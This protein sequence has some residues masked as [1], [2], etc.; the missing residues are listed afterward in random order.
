MRK[1]ISALAFS[2]L[3]A[4]P[5]WAMADGMASLEAFMKN[6][7]A[8]KAQFTQTVT[9]PGRDGQPGRSKT[10]SGEFQFQRPGKFSFN[11][12]KPFEQLIVADGKTLWMLDKDL[13]QVTQRAQAQALGS[14]PAAIL[15]SATDLD[16]LRK[17]FGLANAPDAEGMEWVLAT[18]KAADNQLREVRVGFEAGKLA[19]L[20]ILDSFGQ[21]SLIRFAQLQ[22]LPSLPASAFRFTPPAGADVLK[23]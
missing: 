13:N 23:Q 6:A 9:S 10:S 20:E 4:L 7:Q 21:R 12:T 2:A 14:T 5:L 11:Y 18:P 22:V 19:A 17:D 8:G 15:A 16:G 3:S 1:T